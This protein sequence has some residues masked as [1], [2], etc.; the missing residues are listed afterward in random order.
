MKLFTNIYT[1]F[2]NLSL[3]LLIFGLFLFNKHYEKIQ[4]AGDSMY[5]SYTD[6]EA[7]LV[8]KTNELLYDDV[9]VMKAPDL[10]P[11]DS[12]SVKDILFNNGLSYT[13]YLKRIVAVGGDTIEVKD[14]V[15]YRNGVIIDEHYL[16]DTVQ[17]SDFSATVP[18]G[19]IFALGDN[20][21]VSHDSRDFGSVSLDNIVGY[22]IGGR[23]H[24]K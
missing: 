5:P 6:H 3:L 21:E 17:T 22:V 24:D 20:R 14:N 10:E 4:V 16:E 18:E 7:L 2:V 1:G 19:M 13:Y 9:V 12:T 11:Y 15:M 23:V 8:R